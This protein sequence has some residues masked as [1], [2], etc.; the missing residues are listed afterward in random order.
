MSTLIS[1][2]SFVS[3]SLCPPL[4]SLP[5]GDWAIIQSES[6]PFCWCF[7]N[8]CNASSRFTLHYAKNISTNMFFLC[9]D[10]CDTETDINAE[11]KLSNPHQMFSPLLELSLFPWELTHHTH[12]PSIHCCGYRRQAEG[13]R[14]HWIGANTVPTL[15]CPCQCHLSSATTSANPRCP[16]CPVPLWPALDFCRGTSG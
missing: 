4:V 6:E 5:I 1:D 15:P 10:S 16:W 7:E 8:G 12:T 3:C 11:I 9:F 13:C 2:L 14:W